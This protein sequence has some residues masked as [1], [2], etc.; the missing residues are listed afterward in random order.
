[1]IK[2]KKK[3]LVVVF[4]VST[5][6]EKSM[7]LFS[8]LLIISHKLCVSIGRVEIQFPVQLGAYV[9][10][11]KKRRKFSMITTCFTALNTEVL[12]K[13]RVFPPNFLVLLYIIAVVFLF[14]LR[15][16]KCFAR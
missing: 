10:Q 2:K 7:E 8:I 1:M 3:E 6:L 9:F 16:R 15:K 13:A 4:V 11:N 12:N 5:L 14:S